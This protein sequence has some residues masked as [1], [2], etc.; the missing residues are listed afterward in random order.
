MLRLLPKYSLMLVILVAATA[1]AAT[2]FVRPGANGNGTSWANAWGDMG[3]ISWGSV[4]AGSTVCIAGGTYAQGLAPASSGT[5]GNPVTVKRAVAS[6][7]TCG[8]A[9][10]GWNAAFDAQV[11]MNGQITLQRDFVTIDGMVPNGIKITMQN[12]AGSYYSGIGVGAPTNG[13]VLSHIEVS[14]PCPDA[15]PCAQNGDH[16]SINLNNWNG[17]SYDLQNNMTIQYMNLHGACNLLWSAHST[18]AI[19]QY[20]RFADSMDTTPGNPYCHANVIAT[21]DSTNMTFRYNEITNWEVEGIMVIQSGNSSWQIYGNLWHDPEPGSYS[22]ALEVQENQKGPFLV[23]NNTF[24]NMGFEVMATANGGSY[25]AGSQ[26]RNNIYWNTA[27]GPSLPSDD[28]DYSSGALSE[29]HGEANA[30][31][32]F[33][34]STGANYHL[35][36]HT[37][38]G[39]NLGSPYNTGYDGNART[40]WDRGAYEFGSSTGP[41][42]PT[43]LSALVH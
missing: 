27:S 19:I 17:S 14:G 26:G 10:A 13:V 21:Q 3:S 31:N 15:T 12:P 37:N 5:S 40:T 7:P 41:Q 8:S 11:V 2:F 1:H 32:P 22:R 28:Y 43:G 25:S 9:T 4:T 35:T 39:L 38:A 29:A 20:N 18:N 33:V 36:G 30:A 16:R 34:N 24:V 23:Y 6:D 42:P